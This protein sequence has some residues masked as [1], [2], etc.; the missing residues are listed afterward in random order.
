MLRIAAAANAGLASLLEGTRQ[1]TLACTSQNRPGQRPSYL[2]TAPPPKRIDPV[3]AL[4]RPRQL[5]R[6]YFSTAAISLPFLNPL[7]PPAARLLPPPPPPLLAPAPSRCSPWSSVARGRL[8]LLALTAVL[9]FT[10]R[11]TPCA[12][13]T[14]SIRHPPLVWPC[15]RQLSTAARP[16][17]HRRVVALCC[18]HSLPRNPSAVARNCTVGRIG[19]LT[20]S[21]RKWSRAL[22]PPLQSLLFYEPRTTNSTET[23]SAQSH[24]APTQRSNSKNGTTE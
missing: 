24:L 8:L 14:V 5:V 2:N 21:C 11:G 17:L 7:P 19:Y 3:R 6:A 10:P 4:S 23:F 1:C 15:P 12:R 22:P 9:R 16:P 20:V 13:E 18:A